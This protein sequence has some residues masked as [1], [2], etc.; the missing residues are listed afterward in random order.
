MKQPKTDIRYP[1]RVMNNGNAGARIHLLRHI[2]EKHPT[3]EALTVA[4]LSFRYYRRWGTYELPKTVE[5][6]L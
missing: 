4:E 1:D 2:M 5:Y 3:M 6:E